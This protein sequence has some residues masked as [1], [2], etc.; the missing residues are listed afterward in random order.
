MVMLDKDGLQVGEFNTH[1]R[2]KHFT[3]SSYNSKKIYLLIAKSF[4]DIENNIEKFSEQGS[5]WIFNGP[6]FFDI[7][8]GKV[9]P[10]SGETTI[11]T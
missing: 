4:R 1:F 2:G 9:K 6:N 10:L 8:L 7:Q 3:L 11:K 5:N